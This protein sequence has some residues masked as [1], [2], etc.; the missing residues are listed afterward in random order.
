MSLRRTDGGRPATA[1]TWIEKVL[2]D[3]QPVVYPTTSKRKAFLVRQRRCRNLRVVLVSNMQIV[4]TRRVSDMDA[5]CRFA[6]E[7][8]NWL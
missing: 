2:P 4:N 7:E 8:R 3:A 5:A 1:P 6:E